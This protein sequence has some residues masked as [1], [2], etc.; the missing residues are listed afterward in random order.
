MGRARAWRGSAGQCHGCRGCRAL[1]RKRTA[2]VGRGTRCSLSATGAGARAA[3]CPRGR[4]RTVLSGWRAGIASLT[5]R[6][7]RRPTTRPV[8]SAAASRGAGTAARG[9]GA[10]THSA[11]VAL[12]RCP[13]AA[14]AE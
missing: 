13:G 2:P 11:A 3:H 9:D 5:L 10:T 14:A 12:P 6:P 8:H 4:H 7:S 1:L